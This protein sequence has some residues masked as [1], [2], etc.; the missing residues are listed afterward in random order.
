MLTPK[1]HAL[2][3]DRLIVHI[4]E[5]VEVF[6][7]AS[8]TQVHP[9]VHYVDETGDFNLAPCGAVCEGVNE[10]REREFPSLAKEGCREAAGVSG[11]NAS[12]IGRSN[13]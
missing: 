13:E 4:W 3:V 9:R 10:L 8:D 11:A 1:T 5:A 12:P 2:Q 6:P 7:S